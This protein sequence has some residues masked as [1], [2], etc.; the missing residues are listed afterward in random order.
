M[1]IT[2]SRL[3]QYLDAIAAKGNLDPSDSGHGVFWNTDY[4]S[5]VKGFVPSKKCGGQPV[6]IIKQPDAV[7]SAFLQILQGTW[8][9][10]PAMPQMP[11]TGPFVTDAGYSVTLADGTAVTGET[12]LQ[13]IHDWLA[14]GAPEN[15]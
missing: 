1:A 2:F 7:N 15:G 14:A 6:P 5:F 4:A 11:K 8:C 10:A 3:K 9:T 13:D 12:I